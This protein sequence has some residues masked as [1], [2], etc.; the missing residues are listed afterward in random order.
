MV[1][2]ARLRTR[3]DGGCVS[4]L[5]SLSCEPRGPRA[6]HRDELHDKL[7]SRSRTCSCSNRLALDDGFGDF[8]DREWSSW[9][10]F[11]VRNEATKLL[12]VH[13]STWYHANEDNRVVKLRHA[14]PL[15][16]RVNIQRHTES[17]RSK[18]GSTALTREE[19]HYRRTQTSTTSFGAHRKMILSFAVFLGSFHARPRHSRRLSTECGSCADFSRRTRRSRGG[20]RFVHSTERE[21]LSRINATDGSPW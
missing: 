5:E 3:S 20:P 4:A 9:Q 14:M 2:T 15:Y 12:K 7:R 16:G 17:S 10:G 11:G 19:D 8:E 18:R 13:G 6:D 1:H 21:H